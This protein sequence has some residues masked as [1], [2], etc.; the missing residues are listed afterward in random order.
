MAPPTVS[1]DLLDPQVQVLHS[2]DQLDQLV[3]RVL[4]EHRV[5]KEI[6]VPKEIRVSK[7]IQDHKVQQE[8]VI[9]LPVLLP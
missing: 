5:L 7:E 4:L 9:I 1:Q 6:W 2:K 8:Q 3:L